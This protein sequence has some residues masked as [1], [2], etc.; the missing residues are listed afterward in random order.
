[1]RNKYTLDEEGK[2]DA[3]MSDNL[4]GGGAF[5]INPRFRQAQV[6]KMVDHFFS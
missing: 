2:L 4:R 3:F 6:T 5:K 1:M